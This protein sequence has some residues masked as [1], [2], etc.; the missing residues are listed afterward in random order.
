MP[1]ERITLIIGID[2]DPTPGAFHTKRDMERQVQQLLDQALPHYNPG[3]AVSSVTQST[4]M[5]GQ[6]QIPFGD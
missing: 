4:N 6:D 5:I 2:L 1:R 3:V